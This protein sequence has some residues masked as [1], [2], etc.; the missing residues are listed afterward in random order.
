MER[1]IAFG[2]ILLGIGI[3]LTFS[4]KTYSRKITKWLDSRNTD[5]PPGMEGQPLPQ[6]VAE[7]RDTGDFILFLRIVGVLIMF[8]GASF[9]IAAFLGLD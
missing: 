6:S 4:S 5:R 7:K 3:N 1:E 8:I 9:V 2:V